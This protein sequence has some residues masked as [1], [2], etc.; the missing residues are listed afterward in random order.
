[1]QIHFGIVCIL[2]Y[3]SF[4]KCKKLPCRWTHS[5][6]NRVLLVSLQKHLDVLFPEVCNW[7]QFCSFYNVMFSLKKKTNPNN[8]QTNNPQK[9]MFLALW[10]LSII[11]LIKT[12]VFFFI[13][14][15]STFNS[16]VIELATKSVFL[17]CAR[18]CRTGV[19]MT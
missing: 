6:L 15:N 7:S 16:L 14:N 10:I 18:T 1:M 12:Y 4:C 5:L 11:N 3:Y 8:K 13:Q 2:F 19:N 17:L 9:T